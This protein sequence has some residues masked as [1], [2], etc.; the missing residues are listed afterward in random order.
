MRSPSLQDHY[1]VPTNITSMSPNGKSAS[2]IRGFGKIKSSSI[3][4]IDKKNV[5][6]EQVLSDLEVLR[7]LEARNADMGHGRQASMSTSTDQL[8]NLF[9]MLGHSSQS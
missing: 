5:D 4:K 9:K 8:E 2:S 6:K 3:V 1:T 7:L